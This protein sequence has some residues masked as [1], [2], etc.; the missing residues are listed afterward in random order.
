MRCV[1][2]ATLGR[3]GPRPA[4]APRVVAL[5]DRA[6]LEAVR[7][8]GKRFP[9]ARLR[10]TPVVRAA[11]LDARADPTGGTRVWLALE[12]LQVTGSFKVRGALVALDALEANR[13]RGERGARGEGGERGEVVAASAGNHGAGVAYAALTLGMS[14]TIVVPRTT[15]R[16]K[17][18]KITA[19]GAEL[20]V[21]QSDGYDDAEALAKEIAATQGRVF[22]SPYDDVDVVLGNGSSLGFEIVRALG[23]VPERALVPVGG[24]GLATGLSWA[25]WAETEGSFQSGVWGVQSEAS[26]ALA[27]SLQRGQAVERLA[28]SEETLAEGLEGGITA[29]AFER[30]RAAVAGVVVAS[31]AQIAGAMAHAYR[32]MGLVL[33]GSAAVALVPVLA[34]LPEEVRGGDLVVV[35]T[36]RNVDR[37]RLDRVLAAKS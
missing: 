31:E 14:A 24:G 28:A 21:A 35:L 1:A 17:R 20:V 19:W 36:G 7:H 25:L 8:L 4:S 30:A 23:G 29:G 33:E 9:Q 34:G 2:V 16:A 32:E 27:M 15:P 26:C 6:R 22:V 11:E 18:D 13:A 12:A 37:D 5:P 3:S 10:E